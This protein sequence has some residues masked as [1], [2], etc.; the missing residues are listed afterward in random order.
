MKSLLYIANIRLPT[1]KAHGLQ[2][3]KTCEALVSNGVKVELV[4]P[5]RLNYLKDN[6]FEFYNISKDFSIKKLPCLD[7]INFPVLKKLWFW[8]ETF[9]FYISIK[10]YLKNNKFDQ[11]YTRDLP[12]A[13]WLSKKVDIFYEIH[14]L[15]NIPKAKHKKTWN[16]VKGIFVIS[17]GIKKDLM[18]YGVNE[19]KI[20][21][22]PDAVD[23]AE[24]QINRTKE[25]SRKILNLHHDTKIVLY[26]GH[27]YDWKGADLLA[28]TA[29]YLTEAE[30]YLVGGT[31]EDVRKFQSKYKLKNLH[32]VGWQKHSLMP[33][34]LN[35]ADILVLPNSAK[36]KISSHYT[37]P[38]KLF[39]YMASN[40]PIL[41]SDLPSLREVIDEKSALFFH[42]DSVV[43]LVDGI[44]TLLSDNNLQRILAQNAYSKVGEF[45]W[46]NRA[47]IIKEILI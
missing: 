9:T 25:E 26:T 7:L 46:D 10:K 38:M 28:K 30:I 34:W 1:E 23:I 17:H 29:K 40:R 19:N 41:A 39:E 16:Q 14:T 8:L 43:A 13:L 24:F 3:M 11:Y 32:I 6:P 22:I 5:K 15:P 33:D 35:S 12:I 27:L 4:I 42:P 44:K 21:I 47:K 36:Q 37:S 2:I 20:S 18:K 31:K 45:S